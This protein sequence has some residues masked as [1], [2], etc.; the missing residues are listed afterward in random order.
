MSTAPSSWSERARGRSVKPLCDAL[1][2]MGL[3]PRFEVQFPW[4]YLPAV[5]D[6]PEEERRVAEALLYHAA[7]TV[8][9]MR[10]EI[11]RGA[12]VVGPLRKAECDP[13]KVLSGLRSVLALDI[14]LPE[15]NLAIEFDER[16]HFSEERRVSIDAY[17]DREFPF[18]VMRWREQCT[19]DIYDPL[20]PCRDWQRAFR[21]AVRDLRCRSIGLRLLRFHYL[22]HPD[23]I[24]EFLA[25]H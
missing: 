8:R 22:N 12:R 14:W 1:K 10:S 5:T 18:D 9:I 19:P 21:D 11:Q 20:P 25:K 15:K 23:K 3:N 17:P 2:R 6:A 13:A 24:E 7:K 4:L 16:Q